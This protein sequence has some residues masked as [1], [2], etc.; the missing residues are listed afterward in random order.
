MVGHEMAM[1]LSR[2]ADPETGVNTPLIA[3]IYE[4][5]FL[6]GL[7]AV[8]GHHWI[9]QALDDSFQRAPVGHIEVS[10]GVMPMIAALPGVT[11]PAA[12]VI[13]ARPATA[14]VS[15]PTNLGFF[16]SSCTITLPC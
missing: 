2:Q 5:F 15:R 6:L 14:P 11:K 16:M 7:L 9:L 12:G 3:R 10:A 8:N 1:S 4:N 13:V